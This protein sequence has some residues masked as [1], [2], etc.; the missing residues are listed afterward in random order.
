MIKI[1]VVE[2]DKNEQQ[3][4][5]KYF[6]DLGQET[7][8]KFT[9]SFFNN[10]QEFLFDFCYGIYDLI[11]MDIELSSIDNG[12]EVS[13]KLRK[14]DPDVYL[15]FMTNLAQYAIEGYKVSAFDYMV[16]PISYFDFKNR[17]LKVTEKIVGKRKEKVLLQVDGNKVVVL[18]HDIYYIETI[19]HTLIF[20]TAIGDLK[21]YGALKDIQKELKDFSFSMCNSC[22]LVNLEYVESV[23]GF[24]VKV[25]GH[26][27]QISHPRKKGFLQELSLFL[28]K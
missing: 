3:K 15:I 9:L 17:I 28:G 10:G 2:D 23:N 8:N 26:D 5:N 14:I 18:I 12:I 24:T 21:T 19:S 25:K 1:A 13:E 6:L 11:L 27:L 16:K 7:G 20:H 22:F 4:I